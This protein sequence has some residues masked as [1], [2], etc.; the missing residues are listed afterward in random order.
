[1]NSDAV[2]NY[3]EV[4]AAFVLFS[5]YVAWFV[6]DQVD[7]PWRCGMAARML[8]STEGART[9]LKEIV[10]GLSRK[11][12]WMTAPPSGESKGVFDQCSAALATA[13]SDEEMIPWVRLKVEVD[14]ADL[15][16]RII[17]NWTARTA[18]E[19]EK[20]TKQIPDNRGFG[21]TER[22]LGKCGGVLM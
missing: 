20:L 4:A 2:S 21:L 8:R 13:S 16:A 5:S 10:P 6:T 11:N 9:V 19:I 15:S 14:Y 12:L 7:D 1:L 18:L 17:M 22:M 3:D